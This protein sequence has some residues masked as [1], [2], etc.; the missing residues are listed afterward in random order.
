MP[1]KT[2]NATNVEGP[3]WRVELSVQQ[4]TFVMVVVII[5][6]TVAIGTLIFGCVWCLLDHEGL[7]PAGWCSWLGTP[8]D[9]FS[10]QRW[11]MESLAQRVEN[12]EAGQPLLERKG[13]R[14]KVG[15]ATIVLYKALLDGM[16]TRGSIAKRSERWLATCRTKRCDLALVEGRRCSTPT[17]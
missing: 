15:S 4:K 10:P 6:L 7:C 16:S 2:G 12:L 14:K 17:G 5:A 11:W 8:K 9:T 13:R 3:F 1:G